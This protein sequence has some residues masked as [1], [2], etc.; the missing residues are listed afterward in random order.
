MMTEVAFLMILALLVFGPKKSLEMGQTL[1]RM[2]AKLKHAAS[3]LQSE[4][5]AEAQARDK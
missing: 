1:G 3:Q 2:I 4:L 5:H